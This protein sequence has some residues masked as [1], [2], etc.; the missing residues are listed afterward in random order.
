MDWHLNAAREAGATD[1]ELKETV[2]MAQR[3]RTV[4]LDSHTRF[5][6]KVME[7]L[8]QLP[9]EATAEETADHTTQGA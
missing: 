1:S 8:K 7:L 4:T 2:R 5:T 3:V 9:N 6:A